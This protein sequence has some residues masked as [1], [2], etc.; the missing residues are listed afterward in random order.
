MTGG[1]FNPAFFFFSSKA[2]S[3]IIFSI[4]LRISRISNHQIVGKE[5][6]T[7]FAFSALISVG[8][9]FALTLGYLNPASNNPAMVK[10]VR[11]TGP[12]CLAVYQD[13]G[14]RHEWPVKT[15][16]IV[17]FAVSLIEGKFEKVLRY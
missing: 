12:K 7:E 1:N 10:S 14:T 13:L 8:S 3:R 11:E 17:N 6:Q 4:L 5:N 16:A 9:N 2:L 15:N